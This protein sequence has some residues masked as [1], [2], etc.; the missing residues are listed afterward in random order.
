MLDHDPTMRLLDWAEACGPDVQDTIS[1][2]LDVAQQA[3]RGQLRRS[4]D[5]YI[6]HPVE[7]A[8][9]L[10]EQGVAPETVVTAV[11]HDVPDTAPFY[12]FRAQ[13]GDVIAELV[14][15]VTV[16]DRQPYGPGLRHAD[17]RALQ[18]KIADRLHNMRTIRFLTPK[19]QR[20]KAEHT[21]ELVAPL[22]RSLGLV[23]LAV[24][25]DRLSSATLRS[26]DAATCTHLADRVPTAWSLQV[27]ALGHTLHLGTLVLPH[28]CRDRWRQ[29]WDGELYAAATFPDRLA[30]VRNVLTGLPVM[31]YNTRRTERR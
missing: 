6:T 20:Q 24:E 9:I 26:V 23:E 12:D 25:L 19:A 2:A 31:A 28:H 14:A 21:R 11:L 5:P 10:A 30:F 3:H 15:A 1:R 17:P 22:A 16:L 18:V 4:G 7:V 13:F 27:R 29:D 8:L